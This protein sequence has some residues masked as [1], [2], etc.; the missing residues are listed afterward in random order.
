MKR[1]ISPA[2]EMG[3]CLLLL[4][5]SLFGSSVV[6][7]I[8]LGKVTQS[9]DS[10]AINPVTGLAYVPI[11]QPPA[12]AVID[13]TT[14]TVVTQISLSDSPIC[15]TVNPVTNIIYANTGSMTTGSVQVIDGATNTVITTIPTG[16]E[17]RGIAVETSLNQIYALYGRSYEV[18]VIDGA[19]NSV[20]TTISTGSAIASSVAIDS[21]SHMV[22]VAIP[23]ELFVV[24]GTT[25]SI[26][27][28]VHILGN[29]TGP[30]FRGA[31]VDHTLSQLYLA[32]N[33]SGTLDVV[34]VTTYAINE[35]LELPAPEGVAV[36]PNSHAVWV[37][38]GIQK[39]SVV[40]V[41]PTTLK[42]AGSVNVNPLLYDVEVNSA[43]GDVYTTVP[44]KGMLV[45]A[46]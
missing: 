17:P 37:A 8:A 28:T 32:D 29:G 38:V 45:I 7:K 9:L 36:D 3:I 46:P 21:I 4:T 31:A 13:T 25:N 6:A 15:V 23:G 16:I 42:V 22:Y 40:K 12:I 2:A 33:A 30:V 10:I 41:N 43:T 34:N 11:G 39:G 1:L 27:N 20:L 18:Y 14:N 26:V 35:T 19:S 44:N 5:T 24:D